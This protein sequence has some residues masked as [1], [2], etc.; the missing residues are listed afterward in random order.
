MSDFGF[1]QVN[2]IAEV[3][4]EL[5]SALG[6]QILNEGWKALEKDLQDKDD[7]KENDDKDNSTLSVTSEG[8][9]RSCSDI[10]LLDKKLKL[11]HAFLR[12][13]YPPAVAFMPCPKISLCLKS[14]LPKIS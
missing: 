4:G 8:E 11:L 1:L 6:R 10:N 13:P 12:L 5:F 9:N 3:D 7:E 2:I 14:G